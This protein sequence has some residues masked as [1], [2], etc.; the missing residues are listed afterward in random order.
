MSSIMHIK[1]KIYIRNVVDMTTWKIKEHIH[2]FYLLI[3]SP[4]LP[5]FQ[6]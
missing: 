6:C 1:K 5:I 3:L 4:T 2:F